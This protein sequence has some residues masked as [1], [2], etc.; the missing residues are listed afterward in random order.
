MPVQ[1]FNERFLGNANVPQTGTTQ[2]AQPSGP[3]VS[4]K[5]QRGVQSFDPTANLRVTT[6]TKQAAPH[7]AH[8]GG[9][10]HRPKAVD[11]FADATV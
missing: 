8:S 6:Q 10:D 2:G 9:K 5:G 11:R 4:A 7:A 1:T 3:G